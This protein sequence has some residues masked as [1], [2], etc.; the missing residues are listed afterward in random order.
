MGEE[1]FTLTE[2]R[3]PIRA[4]VCKWQNGVISTGSGKPGPSPAHSFDSS[5]IT[6]NLSA[7]TC[8]RGEVGVEVVKRKRDGGGGGEG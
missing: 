2:G 4:S 7:I 8:E 5:T 3:A 1:R 6:M